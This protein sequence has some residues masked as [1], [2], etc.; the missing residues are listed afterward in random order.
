ME[1]L[2]YIWIFSFEPDE[3]AE[4]DEI[5]RIFGPWFVCPERAYFRRYADAEFQYFD[6]AS[7]CCDEMPYLVCKHQSHEHQYS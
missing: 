3:S 2:M 5:E 7:F 4:R 1:I 6:T